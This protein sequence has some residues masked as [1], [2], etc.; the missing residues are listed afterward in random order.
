MKQT[1][2]SIDKNVPIPNVGRKR[3][4]FDSMEVGDSFLV[5]VKDRS[6]CLAAGKFWVL[7]RNA[8][9]KFT[10]RAEEDMVRIW[11]IALSEDGGDI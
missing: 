7:K 9:I 8:K 10:S 2:Y 1:D 5:T 4:P 3:F 11:K 6:S